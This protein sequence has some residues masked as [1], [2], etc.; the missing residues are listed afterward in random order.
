[1]Y[2]HSFVARRLFRNSKGLGDGKSALSP[3][4]RIS[5]IG[6]ALCIAVMLI[7][8]AITLGFK[9][10]ASTYTRA[11]TG[12]IALSRYTNN[13]SEKSLPIEVPTQILSEIRKTPGVISATPIGLT[14]GIVK[15]D[16]SFAS[17]TV[18]GVDTM[19]DLTLFNSL[20]IEG[21]SIKQFP[22]DNNAAM[23]TQEVASKLNLEIGDKTKLY[24]VD[25]GSIKVRPIII[26]GIYA[27]TK[28]TDPCI[29]KLD[30]L[31]RMLAWDK[32][33]ISYVK[34]MIDN[35][36]STNSIREQLTRELIESPFLPKEYKL[37]LSTTQEMNPE[38]YEWLDMIDSNIYLLLILMALVAGFTMISG[39]VILVLDKVNLIAVFKAM[40]ATN[41]SI[42]LIFLRLSTLLILKGIAWGNLIAFSL[43]CIQKYFKVIKLDREIYFMD[44][45]PISFNL[46]IWGLVNIAAII[47]IIIMLLGPTKMISRISPAKTMRFE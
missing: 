47:V 5:V 37:G 2:Y 9:E 20:I 28:S 18:M 17:M 27:S 32:N 8:V 29:I 15:Q 22:D 16:S 13:P 25:N 24:I 6:V 1:M 44:Y 19:A 45:A 43:C 38:M 12:D 39:L 46:W 7:A 14:A 40:G 21:A 4:V 41:R 30:L 31:Q 36:L 11:L 26:K 33:E 10:Q 35:K 23:I 3:I 34:I 42:R